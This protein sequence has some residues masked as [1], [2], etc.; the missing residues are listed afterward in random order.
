MFSES[1]CRKQTLPCSDDDD[2]DGG[3]DDDDDD[4]DHHHHHRNQAP[5][6][7]N[8][9]FLT[10]PLLILPILSPNSTITHF[11]VF[12]S[13]FLPLHGWLMAVLLLQIFF[14]P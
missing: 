8:R 10:S 3:G 14:P 2:G 12:P 9:F 11:H 13:L 6:L 1:R 7:V 4:H 5:S